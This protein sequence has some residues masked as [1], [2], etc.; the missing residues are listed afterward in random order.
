MARNN[1]FTQEQML[2]LCQ[3]PYTHSVTPNRIVFTVEFKKFFYEQTKVP[4]M[5]TRKIFQAAGYDPSWFSHQNQGKIRRSILAE[6]E[7]PGGFKPPI[8]LSEAE[9]T[10]YFA[11]KDLS[12]QK[13]NETIQ[14]LQ[15]RIVH[16][17]QQVEFLKKISHATRSR[18]SVIQPPQTPSSQ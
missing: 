7:L 8:G 2:I 18:A 1:P 17:E 12:K 4:G 13:T 5:T 3:N 16:L 11:A 15:E 14:E 10:A 6:A 9:K